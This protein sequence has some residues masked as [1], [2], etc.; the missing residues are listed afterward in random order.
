MRFQTRNYTLG[1]GGVLATAVVIIAT[2]MPANQAQAKQ[3]ACGSVNQL[4]CYDQP[5]KIG[6]STSSDSNTGKTHCVGDKK[7][8][9]KKDAKPAAR[10]DKNDTPVVR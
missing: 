3:W 9:M 5:C 7:A 10:V 1:L 6:D 4:T 2:S 8:R